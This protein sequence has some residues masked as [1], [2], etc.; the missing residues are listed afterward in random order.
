MVTRRKVRHAYCLAF[1]LVG[2]LL[3]GHV[4]RAEGRL[5]ETKSQLVRTRGIGLIE[6]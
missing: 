3:T 4:I 5:T 6:G 1:T 2:E